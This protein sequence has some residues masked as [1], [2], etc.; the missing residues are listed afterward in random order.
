MFRNL[1]GQICVFNRA[2]HF[3]QLS[4]SGQTYMGSALVCGLRP[5]TLLCTRGYKR[6]APAQIYDAAGWLFGAC[7][8][9]LTF[10]PY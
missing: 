6:G 8:V 1:A 10:F 2:A 3:D 5:R 9:K 7:N 4:G